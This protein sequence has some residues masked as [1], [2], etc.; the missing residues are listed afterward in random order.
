M[1]VLLLADARFSRREHAFL[2]RLEIGLLGEGPRVLR[3][4]PEESFPIQPDTLGR[5]VPYREHRSRFGRP[6][7][8]RRFVEALRSATPAINPDSDGTLFEI[9]HAF[10]QD[11][12][13][14]SASVAEL[15]GAALIVEMTSASDLRAARAFERVI[16]TRYEHLQQPVW[17][18]PNARIK[19]AAEHLNLSGGVR[20]TPWGVHTPRHA[21]TERTADRPLSISVVCSGVEPRAVHP[22][23][24]AFAK[25]D[26]RRD[27][28]MLFIDAAAANADHGL[29][30]R[31]EQLGILE[32]VTFVAD[33]ESRR[34][35]VLETD[36]LAI[37]EQMGELRTILL[38]AMA[39]GMLIVSRNDP[40]IEATA[41]EGVAM[42][43]D[44]P[45]TDAWL[46]VYR[47]MIDDP[48]LVT[49]FGGRARKRVREDRPAHRHIEAVMQAY[50]SALTPAPIPLSPLTQPP[51][52]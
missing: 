41:A 17:C 25:L 43:I 42:I 34:E 9:V 20:L 23:L 46:E 16:E 1:R 28:A 8:Y 21:H 5:I 45:S 29:W 44:E 40:L 33:M 2:R 49:T 12:W 31:A 26:D 37:P 52:L 50:D 14:R 10:G 11:C 39:A 30:S 48:T 15:T 18:A 22:M 3:A 4:V 7:A 32:Y 38:D 36:V 19:R 35:I 27:R 6:A 47:A 51:A 24:T 13:E